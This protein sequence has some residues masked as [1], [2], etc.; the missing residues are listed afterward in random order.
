MRYFFDLH[1]V[2]GVELDEVGMELP[3]QAAAERHAIHIMGSIAADYH[4]PGHAEEFRLKVRVETEEVFAVNLKL[5]VIR[6]Q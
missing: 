6:N 1:E 4:V 3:D 2:D 5:E